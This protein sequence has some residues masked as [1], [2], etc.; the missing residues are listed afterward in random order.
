MSLLLNLGASKR[1]WIT[2]WNAIVADVGIAQRPCAGMMAEIAGVDI[3]GVDIDG[4]DNDG[5]S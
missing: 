3:S 4:V 1:D 5:V 2:G